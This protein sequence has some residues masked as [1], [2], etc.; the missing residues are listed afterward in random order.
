MIIEANQQADRRAE[1]VRSLRAET[2]ETISPH[3]NKKTHLLIALRRHEQ[4]ARVGEQ[5]SEE[6]KEKKKR[7]T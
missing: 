4:R 7:N 1:S 6:W 2:R 5:E 3:H